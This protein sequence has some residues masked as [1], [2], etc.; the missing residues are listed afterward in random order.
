MYK[1]ENPQTERLGVSTIDIFFSKIGWLF[2]EQ[3]VLDHG[4]DAQVEVVEDGQPTGKLIALQ[5]KTGNSYFSE[6]SGGCYVLRGNKHHYDYWTSHALP[7]IAMLCNPETLNVYWVQ[8]TDE[9]I[10]RTGDGWKILVPQENLLAESEIEHLASLTN[11]PKPL[12]KYNRLKLDRQWIDMVAD[13]EIVYIEFE[14]WIHKSLKRY[15]FRIGCESR[16]N[17]PEMQWPMLYGPGVS[18]EMALNYVIPW[19]S[20]VVDEDS[21]REYMESIWDAE[22]YYCYDKEDGVVHHTMPF[23]EWY[24]PPEGIVP[25]GES[26]G[27]VERYRLILK[28]NDIGNAFLLLDNFL[29]D[30]DIL[31]IGPE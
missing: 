20:F 22:C 23:D 4:I 13:G 5:I 26:A 28:L 10:I 2:R 18:V 1:K 15:N 8:V 9:S 11:I 25:V 27:E 17:I 31:L 3:P 12:Q 6:V 24:R 21:H 7:V 14:D 29:E 16:S 30:D 19:A